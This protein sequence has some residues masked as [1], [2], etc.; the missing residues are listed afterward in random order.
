[1]NF[2]IKDSLVEPPTSIMCFRDL[3]F[4]IYYDYKSV[5]NILI[6]GNKENWDYTW[7]FLKKFGAFDYI[8]EFIQPEDKEVG[9]RL[10]NEFRLAPTIQAVYINEKNVYNILR[11]ISYN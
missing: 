4:W 11:A 9:L 5:E 10:D 1:M 8:A 7:K 3:T 2:I 6:E